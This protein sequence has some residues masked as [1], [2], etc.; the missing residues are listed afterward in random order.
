[1]AK[2]QG[3]TGTVQ[4]EVSLDAAG[5]VSDARILSGPEELRK[6]T[7]Q[8]V[9]DWHFTR[10]AARS[11]RLISISFSE[12]GTQVQVREPEANQTVVLTTKE[13]RR[14]E[15]AKVAAE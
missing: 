11:T 12:K 2:K 4:V 14:V 3:I 13:V 9:L 15:E 8:S 5:D 1:S 6:A 10:D 7:L